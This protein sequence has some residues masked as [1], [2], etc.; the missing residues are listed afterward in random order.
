MLLPT[1]ADDV[2]TTREERREYFINFLKNKPQV[3]AAFR[4]LLTSSHCASHGSAGSARSSRAAPPFEQ[5]HCLSV[6]MIST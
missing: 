6:W 1:V 4:S 3:R 5:H 2:R